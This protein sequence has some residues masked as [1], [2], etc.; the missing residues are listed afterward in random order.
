MEAH[1]VRHPDLVWRVKANR[2]SLAHAILTLVLGWI[3]TVR[4][5]IEKFEVSTRYFP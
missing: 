3:A 4:R 1:R 2:S 5:A